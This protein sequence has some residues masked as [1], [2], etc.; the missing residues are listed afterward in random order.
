MLGSNHSNAKVLMWCVM[1]WNSTIM[2]QDYWGKIIEKTVNCNVEQGY[3][4]WIDW[5]VR[6]QDG[7]WRTSKP[8]SRGT[9]GADFIQVMTNNHEPIS[10]IKRPRRCQFDEDLGQGVGRQERRQ[11][12]DRVPGWRWR[13]PARQCRDVVG[14]DSWRR[15]ARWCQVVEDWKP[16]E[17]TIAKVT[18]CEDIQVVCRLLLRNNWFAKLNHWIWYETC[19]NLDHRWKAII[20]DEFKYN[21]T[22]TS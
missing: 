17:L 1:H 10:W 9:R 14:Y 18:P 7:D 22:W 12:D 13:K 3:L 19:P 4:T 6:R 20:I 2:L 16:R 11:V 8:R 5:C 15:P 21:E